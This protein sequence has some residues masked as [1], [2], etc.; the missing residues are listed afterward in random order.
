MMPLLKAAGRSGII[1]FEV[2]EMLYTVEDVLEM[3]GEYEL[4]RGMLVPIMPGGAEHSV[5]CGTVTVILGSYVKKHRLG[6]ILGN[7]PGFILHRNPDTLRG[8]D[9]AFIPTMKLEGLPKG[10]I[11]GS[12]DLAVEVVGPDGSMTEALHKTAQYLEKGT[13]LVWIVDCKRRRVVV[14]REG[15]DIQTL[16]EAEALSGEDVVP[17]FTCQVADL[18]EDCD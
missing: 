10:F 4:D 2:A 7:D 13:R 18:F 11:P 5:V 17:G 12:P 15:G 6:R 8:P 1:V 3:D 14:Y 16:G 9:V